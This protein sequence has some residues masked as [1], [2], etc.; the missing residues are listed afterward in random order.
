MLLRVA[1]TPPAGARVAELQPSWWR[2]WG[3]AGIDPAADADI[4]ME[5]A[6]ADGRPP[7]AES[8]VAQLE[9]WCHSMR[10]Q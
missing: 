4:V 9:R 1:G 5:E 8:T 3:R 6:D 2:A 10:W 7:A